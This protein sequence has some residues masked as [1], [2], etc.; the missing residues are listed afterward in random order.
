MARSGCR[1]CSRAGACRRCRW[2]G[3]DRSARSP[4]SAPTT[5]DSTARRPPSSSPRRMGGDLEPDVLAELSDRTEGWIASLHMVHAALRDRSPAEIRRFVRGMTGA[6]QELY[7]YL[8]EEVVGD[9]ETEVQRF[10]METAL[11][12]VVTPEFAEVATGREAPDVSRLLTVAERLTLLSRVSGGP[13]THLRYHPLVREFL[14]ARLRTL[15]GREAVAALHRRIGDA[16]ADT[17]WRTAAHHYREAGDTDA[18]LAVVSSADLDDPRQRPIRP[19]RGLHPPHPGRPTSPELRPDPEPGRHAAGRLR[20]RDR[21]LASRPRRGRHRARPTRPRAPQ[22]GHAL[23]EPRRWRREPGASPT[24]CC[25]RIGRL[26]HARYR[27]GD[28]GSASRRRQT[29]VSTKRFGTFDR[30]RP[31]KSARTFI[32]TA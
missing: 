20:R 31:G 3:C 13:R 28:A 14:E 5:S 26:I 23:H 24:V 25:S 29:G 32:T 15:D 7:D 2:R 6:D 22:P 4:S 11:L 27:Q 19:G 10:L 17:D 8:A 30:W 9:L 18:V 12:L 16:A 21:R 1:T